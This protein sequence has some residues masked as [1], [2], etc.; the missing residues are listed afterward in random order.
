MLTAA[1]LSL[2]VSCT[3][4]TPPPSPTPLPT[5][6][7]LAVEPTGAAISPIPSADNTGS[8]TATPEPSPILAPTATTIVVWESLPSAQAQTLAEEARDFQQAFPQYQITLQHYDSPEAFINALT[9]G[10]ADFDVV[11]ASPVL[12]SSLWAADKLAPMSDFFPPSFID[13]FAA[14][15]LQGARQANN[16][17]GLSDTAGFHLLLFY[18]RDL[19]DTP[20]ANTDELLML[21]Q[22]LTQG[23]RW[24][25]GVNSF[26][27]LWVVPWLAAYGGWLT[28]EAGRPTLDTAA[29]ESAL[30]LFQSWQAPS[31]GIAP[32]ATYSEVRDQFVNGNI[33]MVI[34]GEWA[35]G[36]LAQAGD[37]N[38]SVALLPSLGQADDNQ[39]AA[40]LV[41]ARYWAISRETSGNRALAAA[42]FL[43][44]ITRPER[45]LSWTTRYGLL[46][47]RRSALNNPLI[48]NDPILRTSAAQMLAGNSIRL[49]TNANALLD[50]MRDP[51]RAMLEGELTPKAAAEM[52]QAATTGN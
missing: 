6:T 12:L 26:D 34:D 42:A 33:A 3:P 43:D 28:N 50:A 30:T 24:G 5:T 25:L 9:T 2:L 40:P 29:Q 21:A 15:T 16:L 39:P 1:S 23:K 14:T 4:P 20:P 37:L 18:N 27:P 47:T 11:L 32:I 8:P 48:A 51:L 10:D 22:N 46:P 45:Q 19:V 17:W 13:G 31:A 49:G 38:W 52:M 36:E 41:L 7:S 35:I 44:F